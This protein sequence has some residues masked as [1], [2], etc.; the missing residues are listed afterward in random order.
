MLLFYA[1]RFRVSFLSSYSVTFHL[2]EMDEEDEYRNDDE[3]NDDNDND[4]DPKSVLGYNNAT[5]IANSNSYFTFNC[6]NSDPDFIVYAAI[7]S[8]SHCTGEISSL[9]INPDTPTARLVSEVVADSSIATLTRNIQDELNLANVNQ[10]FDSLEYCIRCDVYHKDH[11]EFSIMARKF[12]LSLDITFETSANFNVESILTE[13]FIADDVE[14]SDTRSVSIEVFKG[15][16]DLNP[17]CNVIE[18][19]CFSGADS[20]AI[21]ETLELCI[22]APDADVV[23]KGIERAT[24]AAG[25]FVSPIVR[26]ETAGEV[27][28]T[29]FVTKSE[30][31][32]SGEV[33]LSTLLI[34]AYYDALKNSANDFISV[35][36]VVLLEYVSER[37]LGHAEMDRS[38]LVSGSDASSFAVSIPLDTRDTPLVAR[39]R[40]SS[41]AGNIGPRKASVVAILGIGLFFL[42]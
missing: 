26:S 3:T 40:M 2:Q 37:R 27:G 5:L 14:A 15:D 38:L 25:A 17:T 24:A 42:F 6:T 13:E 9:E 10:G 4:A 8:N 20:V 36:G 32:Q 7:I 39:S 29:N 21:G 28:S 22:K 1:T 11:P 23:I 33:T 18:D 30:V 12:D 31:N 34:P 16:C 35:S 41:S 19:D